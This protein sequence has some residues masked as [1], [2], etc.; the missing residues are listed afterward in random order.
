[1]VHNLRLEGHG[2]VLTLPDHDACLAHFRYFDAT[3]GRCA[4]R[5]AN[6]HAVIDGET[7]TLDRNFLGKH[8]LHGG[9]DGC[10]KRL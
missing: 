3:A 10:V 7:Y 1:M 6:G 4:N 8:T 2:L 5:I 9:G